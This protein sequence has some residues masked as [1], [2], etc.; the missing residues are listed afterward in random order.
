[1]HNIK[2]GHDV[3]ASVSDTFMDGSEVVKY[4]TVTVMNLLKNKKS[5]YIYF[6]LQIQNAGKIN[7]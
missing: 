1:M 7:Y 6:V 4:C 5:Q 3:K 2:E